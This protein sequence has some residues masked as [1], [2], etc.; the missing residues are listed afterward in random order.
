MER[1]MS[2]LGFEKKRSGDFKLHCRWDARSGTMVRVD[3][4]QG[5][6]GFESQFVDITSIALFLADLANIRVGWIAY[7]AQGPKK[8]LGPVG[9]KPP[10]PA[11]EGID[12]YKE[13][14]ELDIL[15]HKTCGN[16]DAEETVRELSSTAD[17]VREAIDELYGRFLELPEAQAGRVP[18]LQID[19][20]IPRTPVKSGVGSK[21]SIN[22]APRLIIMGWVDRPASMALPA[23]EE[24]QLMPGSAPPATG[25]QRVSA[26]GRPSAADFFAAQPA[27]KVI[28]GNPNP[29][30]PTLADFG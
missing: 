14:F 16:P 7:T 6:N 19:R 2:F 15:L 12:P 4:V 21:S 23:P 28:E 17:C 10:K 24:K 9:K 26:P 30:V 25:G 27:L 13:G 20:D 3:R 11:D 1:K 22:Y 18:I 8:A 5:M 29:P